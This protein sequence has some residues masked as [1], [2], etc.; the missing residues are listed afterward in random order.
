MASKPNAVD[1][2]E[3]RRLKID[4]ERTIVPVELGF[5]L[6]LVAS[7]ATLYV[8][9]DRVAFGGP[10][11]FESG[12]LFG[13]GIILAGYKSLAQDLAGESCEKWS[14]VERQRSEP[15]IAIHASSAT[16][17]RTDI[18]K[19]EITSQEAVRLSNCVGQIR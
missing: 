2:Y 14:S 7:G 18:A 10:R 6:A 13:V 12:V 8:F 11:P 1:E 9:P 19:K 16:I 15:T 17:G 5:G 4:R 3:A